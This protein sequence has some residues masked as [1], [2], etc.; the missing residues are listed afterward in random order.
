MAKRSDALYLNDI[1]ES[2]DAI[3][4][5]IAGYDFDRFKSDRKTCSATIR[6]FEVIGE[7]IGKLS[8][9]I[10]TK[11]REVAWRDIKDFRNLLI[12]EYFGVD[13]KILW[14]TAA[15]DLPELGRRIK[16]IIEEEAGGEDG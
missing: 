2:V 11:Y 8:D 14:N 9:N 3:E 10:K 16:E 7:A 12:H 6:E 4:E 15:K 1:L 5:F 13:A